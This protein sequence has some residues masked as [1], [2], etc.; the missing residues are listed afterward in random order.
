MKTLISNA[1]LADGTG[2]DRRPADVLLDGEVIAVVA[3]AG[4]LTAS[5]TGA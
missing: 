3:G 2:T 1:I 5:G 4:S